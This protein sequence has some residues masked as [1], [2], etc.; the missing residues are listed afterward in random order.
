MSTNTATARTNK[1]NST[2]AAAR[3][4]SEPAAAGPNP[5]PAAPAAPTEPSA[6][7][8]V[9]YQ[10][11]PCPAGADADTWAAMQQ[12]KAIVH[13]AG[14]GGADALAWAVGN[15][16]TARAKVESA[17]SDAAPN[18]DTVRAVLERATYA[19]MDDAISA[20]TDARRATIGAALTA[21]TLRGYLPPNDVSGPLVRAVNPFRAAG[22][23]EFNPDGEDIRSALLTAYAVADRSGPEVKAMGLPADVTAIL[24]VITA[25]TTA[26][27]KVRGFAVRGADAGFKGLPPVLSLIVRAM[28]AA[29]LIA[30]SETARAISTRKAITK[31]GG[32]AMATA[33]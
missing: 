7:G 16:L 21:A 2:A 11:E 1:K 24:P 15:N 12:I 14:P 3:T 4:E 5:A 22:P 10:P 26:A 25:E 8:P 18:A 33:K 17:R 6:P 20:I 28:E 30:D 19:Q 27:A 32:R 13:G 29:A 23:S 31:A 9:A